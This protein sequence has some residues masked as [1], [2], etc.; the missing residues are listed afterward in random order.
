LIP[1][2]LLSISEQYLSLPRIEQHSQLFSFY[3]ECN[4]VLSQQALA[5]NGILRQYRYDAS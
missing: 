3:Q 4:T 1:F 2:Q 5:M